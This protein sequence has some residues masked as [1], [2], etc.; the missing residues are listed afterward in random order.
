MV[1]KGCSRISRA[2]QIGMALTL[3]AVSVASAQTYPQ[4]APNQPAKTPPA[5]VA[6]ESRP[7]A[8]PSGGTVVAKKL[9]GLRFV[10]SV[11]EVEVEG[12]AGTQPIAPGGVEFAR[13]ADFAPVVEPFIGQPVTIDSLDQLTNAIVLYYRAHDRPIVNVFA[14]QQN[15]TNGYVQ[16]VIAEGEVGEVT[17]KGAQWFSNDDLRSELRLHAGDPISGHMLREDLEWM[18]RNPFHQS[19]IVFGP[20]TLPA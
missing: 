9:V 1:L 11:K 3:G 12:Y 2:A 7:K 17:A 4:V 14:P 16:I 10:S 8:Q 19:D 5:H 15:I 18:N 13:R 6:A 20:A